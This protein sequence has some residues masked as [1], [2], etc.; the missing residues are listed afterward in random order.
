MVRGKSPHAVPHPRSCC[1]MVYVRD[2]QVLLE[3]LEVCVAN[4]IQTGRAPISREFSRERCIVS[5]SWLPETDGRHHR[6]LLRL[7]A[8]NTV[9]LIPAQTIGNVNI[10]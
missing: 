8:E 4:P 7:A 10:S 1:V 3:L 2:S 5:G 9:P 6:S